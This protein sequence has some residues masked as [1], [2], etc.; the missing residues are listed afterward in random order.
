MA[1]AQAPD[2]RLERV[3]Q[4]LVRWGTILAAG[5][6]ILGGARYLVANG[7]DTPQYAD[8]VAEPEEL[9]SLGG[10]LSGAASFEARGLIQLGLLLL[11]A[12]PLARVAA[13]LVLYVRQRNRLYIVVSSLVLGTLLYSLLAS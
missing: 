1:P 4:A 12:T 8:F 7:G 3:L 10:V 2:E 5:L 9:R 6:I 13:A 11:V